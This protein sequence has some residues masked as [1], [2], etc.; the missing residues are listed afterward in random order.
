MCLLWN[1]FEYQRF[2]KFCLGK[3]K[4]S[5]WSELD[6]LQPESKIIN[7]FLGSINSKG[8]LTINSQPAVNGEKSDSPTVGKCRLIPYVWPQTFLVSGYFYWK[9]F[10]LFSLYN[11]K[12]SNQWDIHLT[13]SYIAKTRWIWQKDNVVLHSTEEDALVD[14]GYV[15][16]MVY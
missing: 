5:P 8:Y 13:K 7:E 9:N 14:C 11:E 10:L 2:I 12:C 3:L 6:G 15:L 1:C 4:S 16:G